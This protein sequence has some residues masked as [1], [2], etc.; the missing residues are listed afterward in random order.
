MPLFLDSGQ[1]GHA[2]EFN[3]PN[4]LTIGLVNNMPDAAVDATERQFVDLLRAATPNTVVLV[5]LFAIPELPRTDA[6][7]INERLEH[8]VDLVLDGGNCGLVP[9]SVIDLSGDHAVVVRSGRGDVT[10]FAGAATV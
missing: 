4:C 6:K 5:K 7:E 1:A 3:A 9:T 10:P 8:S 2:V